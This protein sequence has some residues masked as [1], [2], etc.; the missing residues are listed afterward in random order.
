ML[1]ASHAVHPCIRA[2]VGGFT[3][4]GGHR[5]RSHQARWHGEGWLRGESKNG[6]PNN[7][8]FVRAG[9]LS[10]HRH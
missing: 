5:V 1:R 2:S 6:V 10:E 3:G 8:R 7:T 9:H 4:G